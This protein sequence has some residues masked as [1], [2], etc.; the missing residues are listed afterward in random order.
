MDAGV[1]AA[2]TIHQVVTIHQRMS[3]RHGHPGARVTRLTVPSAWKKRGA[4]AFGW[5]AMRPNLEQSRVL[6]PADDRKPAS[7]DDF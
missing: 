1:E 4:P 6:Y 5:P 2:V 3:P 7:L